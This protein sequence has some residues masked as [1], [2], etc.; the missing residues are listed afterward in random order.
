MNSG[1]SNNLNRIKIDPRT[2]EK[3]SF[4]GDIVA[5]RADFRQN[6]MASKMNSGSSNDL[7]C[8]RIDLRTGEKYSFNMDIHIVAAMA[9]QHPQQCT[10]IHARLFIHFIQWEAFLLLYCTSR[11][12]RPMKSVVT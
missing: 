8:I 3:F 5:K 12:C 10:F 7:N 1:G 9:W 6:S 2:G 11:H 4:N